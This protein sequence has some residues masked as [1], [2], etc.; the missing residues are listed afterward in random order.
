V[1][2]PSPSARAPEAAPLKT[3]SPPVFIAVMVSCTVLTITGLVLL[4][5]LKMRGLW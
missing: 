4:A 1:S 3:R 5:Y 2:V